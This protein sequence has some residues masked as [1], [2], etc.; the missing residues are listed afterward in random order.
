[1][2]EVALF[3]GSVSS[4]CRNNEFQAEDEDE[5]ED[6]YDSGTRRIEERA[7]QDTF[8]ISLD[9]LETNVE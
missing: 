7:S 9:A 6:D 8:R 4:V 3:N 1:L 5:F 2:G